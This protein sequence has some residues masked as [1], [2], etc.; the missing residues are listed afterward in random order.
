[1]RRIERTDYT[2]RAV[3]PVRPR[4]ISDIIVDTPK[5][6]YTQP[7]VPEQIVAP[8]PTVLKQRSKIALPV[9]P[10]TLPR[11]QSSNTLARQ[12]ITK[13]VTKQKKFRFN[14]SHALTAA[15]VLLLVVGSTVSFMG[16][17]TNRKVAAQV[18][19]VTQHASTDAEET[20][21]DETKPSD[22]AYHGHAVA[23]DLPR[24][25]RIPKLGVSSMVMRTGTTKS[26]AMAVPNNIYNTGWYDGSSKPGDAGATLI[27]GH[28]GGPTQDGVFHELKKLVPG[29]LIELERGDGKTYTFKVVKAQAQKAD[30]V[31]MS[32]L[33]VP[34]TKG[35]AGLNLI[36]CTGKFS[37]EHYDQR[38]TVFA[39]QVN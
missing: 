27:A 7:V 4:G 10:P 24:Y 36:T 32:D 3:I 19:S 17:R 34:I 21:P 13:P 11:Y 20:T 8:K 37:G 31:D 30:A 15:A 1:M 28:A 26:G 35:K 14:S 16:W 39:T 23:P 9:A 18:Q 33:L 2:R 38:F 29:D 25:L 22:A 6:L 12:F 5:Q